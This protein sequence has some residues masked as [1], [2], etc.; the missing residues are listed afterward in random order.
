MLS[1]YSIE[2]LVAEAERQGKK[3]SEVVIEDQVLYME[4]SKE[5]ILEDMAKNYDVMRGPFDQNKKEERRKSLTGLSGM[6]AGLMRDAIKNGKTIVGGFFSDVMANALTVSEH[7]AGM[8]KIVAAPTAG[9]SGILPAVLVAMETYGKATREDIIRSIFTAG[10]VG[11]VIANKASISGAEGGCQAECGSAAAM[12]AA[13][14]TELSGGSP[15]QVANAATIAIKNLMGLVCDPVC[16]LVEVPCVKRNAGSA[17]IAMASAEMAMAGI[18]SVI[19]PDEV[20][21][22]MKAVGQALP[23]SLRETAEGGLATTPTARRLE[24]TI[25]SVSEKPL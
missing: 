18:E 17:A 12:A 5:K 14:L 6:N 2:E 10:A 15:K 8:G 24:K 1:Y 21:D 4:V 19:P 16:G 22:A 20:I 11:M 9:A 23:V 13:A 3:I 7:N 25:L